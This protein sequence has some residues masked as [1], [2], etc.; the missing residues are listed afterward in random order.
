MWNNGEGSDIEERDNEEI[1]R[2][3]VN[4][5]VGV[6]ALNSPPTVGAGSDQTLFLPDDSV[7]LDGSASDP[8]GASLT[9]AWTKISGP[10]TVTFG[11]A[12]AVDTTATFGASGTYVLRL[13]GDDGE[14]TA[15]DEVTI[16]VVPDQGNVV[17][18]INSGGDAYTAA[19]GVFYSADTISG[20]NTFD[21]DDPIS[22]TADDPIYQSERWGLFT[23]EVSVPDGTYDVLLQFAEIFQT[24]DGNRVFD[25]LVEGNLAANN[26]DIHALVG[27]D[28]A[29]DILVSGVAV[30]DGS[31]TITSVDAGVNNPKLS[32]FRILSAEV[33]E[34]TDGD[35][36][37]DFWEIE[38]FG[39]LTGTNGA[40]DSDQ[41][42]VADFFEYLGDADPNDPSETGLILAAGLSGAGNLMTLSWKIKEGFEIGTDYKAEVSTNLSQWNPLPPEHYDLNET[43][44]AGRTAVDMTLTHDYGNTVFT[45]LT[46]P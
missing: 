45:R 42:G 18:A 40:I 3:I 34:D 44:T 8:E 15:F 33:D 16:T 4:F 31:L 10:G 14:A 30:S 28:A 17:T 43:T 22:G 32:G 19:D 2:R 5:L 35:G 9:T 38:H 41:N 20:G 7:N 27:H 36:I 26:L 37:A 11:D 25:M 1:L 21:T 29:H 24:S 39:N 12:S 6:E 46:S 13:T 23:Y